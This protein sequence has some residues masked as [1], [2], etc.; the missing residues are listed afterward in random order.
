MESSKSSAAQTGSALPANKAALL[1]ENCLMQIAICIKQHTPRLC[2]TER[3]RFPN[4]ESS[5]LAC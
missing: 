5:P 3:A 4:K 1:G 2:I